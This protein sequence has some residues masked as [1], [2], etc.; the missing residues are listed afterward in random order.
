VKSVALWR[1]QYSNIVI[2]TPR[3]CHVLYTVY[4]ESLPENIAGWRP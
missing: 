1:P 2:I 3:T 4:S